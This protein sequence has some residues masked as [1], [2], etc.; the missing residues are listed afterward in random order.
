MAINKPAKQISLYG[1]GY[2]ASHAVEGNHDTADSKCSISNAHA[3][4]WLIVDLGIPLTITGVYLTNRA[5]T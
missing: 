2:P 4:P 5:G 3:N 1:G